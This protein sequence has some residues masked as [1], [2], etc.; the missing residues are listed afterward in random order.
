MNEILL[1][2]YEIG[3]DF[4]DI[5]DSF[6]SD[7]EFLLPS[8][9]DPFQSCSDIEVNKSNS[10]DFPATVDCGV[11]VIPAVHIEEVIIDN[12]QAGSSKGTL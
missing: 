8:G 10:F 2:L 3:S 12:L 11:K 6:E 5:S 7:D 4:S 9:H 1:A